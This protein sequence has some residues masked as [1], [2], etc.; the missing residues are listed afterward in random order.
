MG[1]YGHAGSQNPVRSGSVRGGLPYFASHRNTICAP[2]CCGSTSALLQLSAAKSCRSRTSALRTEPS[3]TEPNPACC[4]ES[5]A[6]H[7]VGSE[8]RSWN[9]H[10]AADSPLLQTRS[11]I[12]MQT[13]VSQS[14]SSSLHAADQSALRPSAGSPAA[15]IIAESLKLDSKP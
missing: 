13:A 7:Q 3:R 5:G 14:A 15:H 4:E 9:G 6:S 2:R 11:W 10:P 12:C 8:S 1:T